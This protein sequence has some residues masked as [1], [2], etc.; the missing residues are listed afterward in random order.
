VGGIILITQARLP[1]N[2]VPNISQL[3]QGKIFWGKR[4]FKLSWREAASH[5]HHDEIVDS[6]Q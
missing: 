2:F 5:N 3:T 1:D 6:D 4:E